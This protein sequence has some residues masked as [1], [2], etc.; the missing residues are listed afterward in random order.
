MR[1]MLI[2]GMMLV[3]GVTA[4]DP[5]SIARERA[6]RSDGG[7]WIDFGVDATRLDGGN[8]LVYR[9][10]FGRFAPMMQIDRTFYIGGELDIGAMTAVVG[11]TGQAA[12]SSVGVPMELDHAGTVA[13]GKFVAGARISA[14]AFAGAIE[15]A[16]GVR[17]IEL[18]TSVGASLNVKTEPLLEVRGR[19]D[20][21][22]TQNA[23]VGAI[24]GADL[25]HTTDVMV[26]LQL[27]L[28]FDRCDHGRC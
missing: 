22:A 11:Q 19:L 5:M 21:W 26:G 4:A 17:Y 9:G 7:M 20:L 28:H 14:G 12:R 2:S 13:A 16:P 24:V 27:G 3:A 6:A 25:A 23:T 8:G 10:E 18:P 15:L 1:S